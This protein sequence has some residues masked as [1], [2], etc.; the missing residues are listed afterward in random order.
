MNNL[1]AMKY[2]ERKAKQ[3]YED[4]EIIL[5]ADDFNG[6]CLMMVQDEDGNETGWFEF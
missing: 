6:I 1:E 4:E 2:A 5:T 3:M